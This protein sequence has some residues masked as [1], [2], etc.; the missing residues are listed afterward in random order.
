MPLLQAPTNATPSM[1]VDPNSRPRDQRA[2]GK[3]PERG[4][5]ADARWFFIER[6]HEKKHPRPVGAPKTQDSSPFGPGL[7]RIRIDDF[8]VRESGPPSLAFE[9]QP[10]LRVGAAAGLTRVRSGRNTQRPSRGRP[11]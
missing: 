1:R 9:P 6:T 4:G 10:P 8:L 3:C 5:S 7:A 11:H 2:E